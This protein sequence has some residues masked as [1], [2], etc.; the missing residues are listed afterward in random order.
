MFNALF[1]L[2]GL[3]F[4]IVF[5][6]ASGTT[7]VAVGT[8]KLAVGTTTAA[9]TFTLGLF[10]RNVVRIAAL[11]LVGYLVYELVTGYSQGKAKAAAAAPTPAAPTPSSPTAR[12]SQPATRP[13]TSAPAPSGSP[14]RSPLVGGGDHAGKSVQIADTGGVGHTT[15]V[16]RGVI[17]R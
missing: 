10:L 5:G 12:Q 11:S 17:Q 2:V 14:A 1:G 6:V 8:T 16:G 3:V 4:A 9:T 13:A 7:K 15:R